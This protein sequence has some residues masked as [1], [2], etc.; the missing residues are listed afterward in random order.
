[1][2]LEGKN[3]VIY[4]AGGSIGA[5]VARALA[6]EGA[7]AS[8]SRSAPWNPCGGIWPASSGRTASVS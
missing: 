1:M 2:L 5:A 7:V 8:R 4:G 3:A 6:R